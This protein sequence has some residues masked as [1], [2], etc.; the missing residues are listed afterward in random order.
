M[1]KIVYVDMDGVIVDFQS[2]LDRV[3]KKMRKKYK[4]RK[5]EI[6]RVFSL[7]DPMPGAVE[8]FRALQDSDAYDAYVLSTA[9]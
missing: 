8:S 7:M 5:D 6:P 3:G 9:S 2:G 4:G 1:T